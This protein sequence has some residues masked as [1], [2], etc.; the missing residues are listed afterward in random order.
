MKAGCPVVSTNLS[1]IPE[2]AGKAALLVD[3]LE[4]DEFTKAILKLEDKK[5]RD[6]IIQKGLVQ[7]KK[8]SWD[9]CFEETLEFYKKVVGENFYEDFNNYDCF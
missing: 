3:K 5:F 9:K 6:E 2:V 4:V 8:F 1:S 7:T